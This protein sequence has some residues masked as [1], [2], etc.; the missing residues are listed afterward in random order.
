M[1]TNRFKNSDVEYYTELNYDLNLWERLL[2]VDLTKNSL[3]E[4]ASK[5]KKNVQRRF[6]PAS[7]RY[8]SWPPLDPLT[9][10]YKKSKRKLFLSGR[11]S[12]S[13]RT[14][15]YAGELVISSKAP[16]S[17]V[18]EKGGAIKTT[19]RQSLWMHHHLFN[20]KSHPFRPKLIVIPPR[21]FMGFDKADITLI[22]NTI[23]AHMKKTERLGKKKL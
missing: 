17:S 11:L 1:K 23:K 21:P 18:Q 9:V 8:R 10:K 5:L 22:N 20:K 13:I 19:P 7:S 12:R 16:Y 14:T 3:R 6:S 15:V 2:G 4:L